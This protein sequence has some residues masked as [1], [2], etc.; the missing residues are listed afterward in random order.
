MGDHREL[1]DVLPGRRHRGA[2]DVGGERKFEREQ[3]PGGKSE[4]GL[5]PCDLVG[6]A[7][8]DQLNDRAKGLNG[9]EATTRTAA[10]S[11]VSATKPAI[12]LKLS[13]KSMAAFE[14]PRP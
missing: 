1:G 2:N 4:P 3:N 14:S 9:A 7:L 6:G 10:A 11:M 8:K 13:S 12:S 5:P